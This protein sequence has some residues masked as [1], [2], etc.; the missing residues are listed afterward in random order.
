MHLDTMH[1]F[2]LNHEVILQ[3]P[4]GTAPWS[5]KSEINPLGLPNAHHG[6]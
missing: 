6:Y 3:E 4:V 5:R 1:D 2:R